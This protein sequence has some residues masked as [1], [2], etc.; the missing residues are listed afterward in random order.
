VES[1]SFDVAV[2]R[3]RAR[4][5]GFVGG[6]APADGLAVL[7]VTPLVLGDPVE[8]VR[9]LVVAR[10][11]ELGSDEGEALDAASLDRQKQRVG[12]HHVLAPR[13]RVCR[14]AREDEPSIVRDLTDDE[15]VV[16]DG[17]HRKTVP[18][19]ARAV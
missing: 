2:P 16:G 10:P 12:L 7:D 5:L 4:P 1:A 3:D 14:I 18:G 6:V 13:A 8:D 11:A 19:E 15:Q 17:L 9:R